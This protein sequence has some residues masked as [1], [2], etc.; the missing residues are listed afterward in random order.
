MTRYVDPPPKSPTRLLGKWGRSGD[1]PRPWSTPA[2]AI[3]RAL[4][5]VRM[6]ADQ[7]DWANDSVFIQFSGSVSASGSPVSRIGTTGAVAGV[8]G[9]FFGESV[10]EEY[11][12]IV[13]LLKR[14]GRVRAAR[15]RLRPELVAVIGIGGRHID[16]TVGMVVSRVAAD[17]RVYDAQT[18]APMGCLPADVNEDGRLDLVVVAGVSMC[19]S[20]SDRCQHGRVHHPRY[21]GCRGAHS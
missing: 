18:M 4:L 12:E 11:K 1:W 15:A 5:W 20:Q 9:G 14:A 19:P 10:G 13:G 6:R 8:N 21:R 16:F 7:N 3:Q 17:I 2:I